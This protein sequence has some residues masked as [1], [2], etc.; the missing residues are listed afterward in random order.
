MVN[1]LLVV[2]L[3]FL[4]VSEAEKL[5]FDNYTVYRVT[6]KTQDGLNVLRNWEHTGHQEFNFWSSLNTADSPVDIMVSPLIRNTFE[7]VVQSKGMVSEI[8]I[9]NVQDNIDGEG[10]RPLVNAGTFGFTNYHTLD[11]VSKIT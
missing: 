9:K 5:R 10:F 6:P 2:L 3:T 4:V 1:I 11:E 8:L 7:E